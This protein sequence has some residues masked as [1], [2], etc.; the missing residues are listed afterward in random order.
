MPIGASIVAC[1]GIGRHIVALEENKDIF[2]AILKPMRNS[3]TTKEVMPPPPTF[4]ISH[5]P[6]AM[7]MVP[8]KFIRKGKLSK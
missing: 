1:H 7:R 8:C 3:T 2:K 4:A 5:N 6:D